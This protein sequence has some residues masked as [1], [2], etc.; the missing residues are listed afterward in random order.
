MIAKAGGT[1][2][3][4]VYLI[5]QQLPAKF[6]AESVDR[7]KYVALAR[8]RHQALH[9]GTKLLQIVAEKRKEVLE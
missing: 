8:R 1:Q 4:T 2:A 7:P 3:H 6:D 9:P 5:D